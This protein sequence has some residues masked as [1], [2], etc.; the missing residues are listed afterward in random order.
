[1]NN[2]INLTFF[3]RDNITYTLADVGHVAIH[4]HDGV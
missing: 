2:L 4:H 3:T 1:M